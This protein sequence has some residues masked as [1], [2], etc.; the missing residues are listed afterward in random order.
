MGLLIGGF[1]SGSVAT[2][3]QGSWMCSL[4]WARSQAWSTAGLTGS[5]H[6]QPFRGCTACCE[7]GRRREARRWSLVW[8]SLYIFSLSVELGGKVHKLTKLLVF[9]IFI[10]Y[11]FLE[12]S[13]INFLGCCWDGMYP[14]GETW[15]LDCSEQISICWSIK[16]SSTM[17]VASLRCG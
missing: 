13:L 17:V 5:R 1:C 8:S 15:G 6:W 14:S 3:A 11:I 12:W 10:L 4:L 7:R 2:G 9:F 16:L